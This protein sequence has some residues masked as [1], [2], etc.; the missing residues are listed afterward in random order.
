[1]PFER[2]DLDSMH[3]RL[4]RLEKQN[5][6][7]KQLGVAIL[8][9][10]PALLLLTCQSTNVATPSQAP[11]KKTVEAIEFILKDG[12]GNVRARLRMGE[13]NS[14]A[15]AV[16]QL[17]LLDEKGTLRVQLTGGREPREGGVNI[18]NIAGIMVFDQDGHQRGM[19]AAENHGATLAFTNVNGV[20][21]AFV[22][23]E[24]IFVSG[25][26]TVSDESG[27]RATLG[28]TELAIPRSGERH[29]TS[30]ASLIMLNKEKNVIWRA[31]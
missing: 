6:R 16:P 17:D 11:T 18:A 23:G 14:P 3:Q 15:G 25:P 20:D 9:V 13:G 4:L 28:P 1:M 10:I 19:F 2:N 30:A 12:N 8:L 31:P 26:V 29:Q 27:F 21:D 22:R 24:G 5:R 7:F